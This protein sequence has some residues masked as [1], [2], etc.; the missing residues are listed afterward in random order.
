M[1]NFAF[2]WMAMTMAVCMGVAVTAC[3]DDEDDNGGGVSPGEV[4]AVSMTDTNG[5]PVY[6]RSI[7]SVSFEYDA[8]GKLI[9]FS[10]DGEVYSIKGNSFSFSY[11]EDGEEETINVS[12]NK[13]GLI[14]AISYRFYEKDNHGEEEKDEGKLTYSY[15]GK[16]QLT[17]VSGNGSWSATDMENGKKVGEWSG[18]GTLKETLTWQNDNLV[19]ADMT[20]SSSETG[21]YQ[22]DGKKYTETENNKDV[23]IY[24]Y[25]Y[26][27]QKNPALQFPY[28]MSRSI[29]GGEDL[30]GVLAIVGFF[31][32]GPANLPTSGTLEY[33]EIEDG[34]VDKEGTSTQNFEFDMNANGTIATEYI[35]YQGSYRSTAAQYSYDVTRVAQE[36]R[37]VVFSMRNA[38]RR[39]HKSHK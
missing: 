26:G 11:A 27:Q 37:K 38:L 19:R 32:V 12:V 21:T 35:A 3:G 8:N 10:N 31:G 30:G 2:K 33:K 18:K 20:S 17:S 16:K 13:Q 39:G 1:K 36:A 15:N 9:S 28:V 7:G 25:T 29:V 24:T 4:P 34:E 22:E 23:E 14:S 6:V 5:N